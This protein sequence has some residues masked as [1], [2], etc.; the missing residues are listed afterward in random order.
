LRA[1]SD[2]IFLEVIFSKLTLF[3]TILSPTRIANE[4]GKK[5]IPT[6]SSLDA[7]QVHRQDLP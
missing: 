3:V 1:I 5:N 2:V 4:M 7:V 6:V